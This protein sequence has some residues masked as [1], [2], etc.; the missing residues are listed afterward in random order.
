MNPV[1]D[2]T[3]H[4]PWPLPRGAWRMTQ[5]WNNLLFAHWPIPAEEVQATLPEGLEVD[6]FDGSAWLGVVPFEMA[7][8][9]LRVAGLPLAV[10]SAT[11]F[12]ELNLRTY[13]R[14][15]KTGQAGVYF[16]ALE[17]ASPLAVATARTWFHLPYHWASMHVQ[18]DRDGVIHYRSHRV[19]GGEKP[20]ARVHVRYRP[21]AALEPSQPGSLAH[22]LTERYALF[23]RSGN[24]L[25]IGH[26]HH[27]PWPLQTAQAAFLHNDLPAAYGFNLPEQEPVL[28]FSASLQVYIWSL[29][30]L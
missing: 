9:R 25:A 22:F 14:S 29:S 20:K 26:I 5:F 6:T 4:R 19:L 28:H 15:R 21:V 7:R 17:A 11:S 10:P 13:V 3:G 23:T 8:V 12:P 18:K 30:H 24:G 2:A 1:L 16:Y 27:Q